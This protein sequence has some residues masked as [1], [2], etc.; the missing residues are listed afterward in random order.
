MY[1]DLPDDVPLTGLP[2]DFL[3]DDKRVEEIDLDP[4]DEAFCLGFPQAAWSPGGFPILRSGHIASYPLTPMKNVKE[5]YF[6]LFINGGNSGGPVYY[7]YT[8]RVFKGQAHLG[9]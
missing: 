3:S 2:P 6:D 9:G 5:I 1:V 7:S 4:G 8:S